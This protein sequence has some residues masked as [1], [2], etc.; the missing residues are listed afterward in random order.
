V[1][2]LAEQVVHWFRKKEKEKE[3]ERWEEPPC[4]TCARMSFMASEDSALLRPRTRR[5]CRSLTCRNGSGSS[6]G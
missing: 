5:I 6:A 4:P 1:Y 2:T 3:K